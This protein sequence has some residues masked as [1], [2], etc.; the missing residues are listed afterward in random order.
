MS[1]S[2][3]KSPLKIL[4]LFAA[5]AIGTTL[6]ISPMLLQC[7]MVPP[8]PTPE[9]AAAGVAV[10]AVE[11]APTVL[12]ITIYFLPVTDSTGIGVLKEARESLTSDV[13]HRT[14]AMGS[15]LRDVMIVWP[16][17]ELQTGRSKL[18]TK[19]NALSQGSKGIGNFGSLIDHPLFPWFKQK[20]D[21]P[22][23]LV[24]DQVASDKGATKSMQIGLSQEQNYIVVTV[25]QNDASAATCEEKIPLTS[26][27]TTGQTGEERGVVTTEIVD[28]AASCAVASIVKTHDRLA[29]FYES[30]TTGARNAEL[31]RMIRG[32][33]RYSRF[34]VASLDHD[35]D[36]ALI[37]LRDA[38]RL[39]RKAADR[40]EYL[41]AKYFVIHAYTSLKHSFN[42]GTN[43]AGSKRPAEAPIVDRFYVRDRIKEV[44]SYEPFRANDVRWIKALALEAIGDVREAEK[45]WQKITSEG[46]YPAQSRSAGWQARSR[47]ATLL[48]EGKAKGDAGAA[49]D[50][51]QLKEATEIHLALLRGDTQGPLEGAGRVAIALELALD[52]MLADVA[53][54]VL[55]I[56]AV[57]RSRG[58]KGQLDNEAYRSLLEQAIA[59]LGLAGETDVDVRLPL[60][61]E[62]SKCTMRDPEACGLL[63]LQSQTLLTTLSNDLRN[64]IGGMFL[65]SVI[66]TSGELEQRCRLLARKVGTQ[67]VAEP[68]MPPTDLLGWTLKLIGS[69]SATYHEWLRLLRAP[70]AEP[71]SDVA[72]ITV[73]DV[74][75]YERHISGAGLLFALNLCRTGNSELARH[76]IAHFAGRPGA[77]DDSGF[78]PSMLIALCALAEL[79]PAGTL[80]T[81]AFLQWVAAPPE[82]AA[83]SN[84][85]GELRAMASDESDPFTQASL[86]LLTYAELW[87]VVD[88]YAPW[89]IHERDSEAL[90]DS[91]AAIAVDA[92]T[93][94]EFVDALVAL[95]DKA[96]PPTFSKAAKVVDSA[97]SMAL[98]RTPDKSDTVVDTLTAQ[99]TQNREAY[100]SWVRDQFV[101]RSGDRTRLIQLSTRKVGSYRRPILA[102]ADQQFARLVTDFFAIVRR[103][104][105]PS[106][107]EF[108]ALLIGDP[109]LTLRLAAL[110]VVS[111]LRQTSAHTRGA[112][113]GPLVTGLDRELL[114]GILSDAGQGTLRIATNGVSGLRDVGVRFTAASSAGRDWLDHGAWHLSAAHLNKVGCHSYAGGPVHV[115]LPC[116]QRFLLH[117]GAT[118]D[119]YKIT[120]NVDKHYVDEALDFGRAFTDWMK[121]PLRADDALIALW[122]FIQDEQARGLDMHDLLKL[123]DYPQLKDMAR[124]GAPPAQ[125]IRDYETTEIGCGITYA[126]CTVAVPTVGRG[127]SSWPAALKDN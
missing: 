73:S 51:V 21:V 44:F 39:F 9:T 22:P 2:T 67:V 112:P 105:A 54:R 8:T 125:A 15:A 45:E 86:G 107:A 38:L 31:A 47:Q 68:C 49:A 83:A 99:L 25:R 94:D 35:D 102:Q 127:Y 57:F 88:A 23:D 116:L 82:S 5:S 60:A 92:L 20:S 87:P 41:L 122:W 55:D 6:L 11:D 10:P 77:T 93:D 64:V 32:I 89:V 63:R 98:T 126:D 78:Q 79:M 110:R 1:N 12:P 117:I 27:I 76:A 71:V 95:W 13:I 48:R 37:A 85:I 14:R 69:V 70:T 46:T 24:A 80:E 42:E 28:A 7:V 114:R 43:V 3:R 101:S 40:S 36:A 29:P 33:E 109:R 118:S 100:A 61:G 121:W 106:E 104:S 108:L 120:H 119:H 103:A 66:V 19:G 59:V 124:M 90:K 65:R 97:W 74:R 62:I 56:G 30:L 115:G 113:L 53:V 50:Q 4:G 81:P 52:Y 96:L 75:E 34:I 16:L 91:A 18:R 111:R 84:L 58:I 17:E 26:V 123:G 72:S